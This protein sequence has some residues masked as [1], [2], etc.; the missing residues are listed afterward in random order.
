MI[1]EPLLWFFAALGASMVA[2]SKASITG[3]SILSIAL[4]NHVFFRSKQASGLVLPLAETFVAVFS[5]RKHTQWHYPVAVVSGPRRASCSAILRSAISTRILIGW[6]SSS[7]LALLSFWRR[8]AAAPAAE[9]GL[10]SLVGGCGPW[11][12]R[13]FIHPRPPTPPGRS[14]P[15]I[16]WRLPSGVRRHRRPYSS[17]SSM[18]SRCRSWWTLD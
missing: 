3:L 10:V 18:Y 14:W 1:T 7:R 17:C 13:R 2:V 11:R 6:T 9:G 15:S 12:N 4:F 8:H 16:L 5:Y